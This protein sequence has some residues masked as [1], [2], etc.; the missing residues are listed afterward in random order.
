MSIQGSSERSS[1]SSSSNSSNSSNS[2][3]DSNS[4]G[5][6]PFSRATEPRMRPTVATLILL[7]RVSSAMFGS[8]HLCTRFASALKPFEPCS[9]VKS[10]RY[11]YHQSGTGSS[12]STIVRCRISRS[13]GCSCENQE[14]H[15][16]TSRG[17]G[18]LLQTRS[19]SSSIILYTKS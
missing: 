13:P 6:I 15:V 14:R 9:P 19:C 11:Q 2:S 8:V 7:A 17:V 5:V 18:E 10:Y 3:V 16:L 4:S 12:Y 1:S